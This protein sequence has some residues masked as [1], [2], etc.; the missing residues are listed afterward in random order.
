MPHIFTLF[1]FC[2]ILSGLW[3]VAASAQAQ[4]PQEQNY[5][6]PAQPLADALSAIA[7]RSRVSIAFEA[8]VVAQRRSAPARGWLTPQIAL[9]RTLEGT[10]LVVRFTGPR[11]AI[12]YN[13]R[14]EAAAAVAAAGSVAAD[15]PTLDFGVAVV[16][17]KRVIGRRDPG[18]V[19]DYVR[20]ATQEIQAIF[21]TDPG[22]RGGTFK[23]RI[24]VA[25]D[26]EG[27]IETAT[28]IQPSGQTERDARAHELVLGRKIGSAPPSGLPQPLQFD[29]TGARI[30]QGGSP[31]R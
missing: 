20:R 17:A 27:R 31:A 3:P 8:D 16:R 19:H 7:T 2:A 14:S 5:D 12:V 28:L 23:F 22:Y 4:L 15:R 25:I 1:L 10:G 18:A 6:L 26:S 24:A 21:A 9:R 29:I 11:S 13:P 30:G